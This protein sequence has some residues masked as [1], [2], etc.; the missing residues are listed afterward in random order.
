VLD[1]AVSPADLR[2][3]ALSCPSCLDV[4]SFSFP[5][6]VNL[7]VVFPLAAPVGI[8]AHGGVLFSSRNLSFYFSSL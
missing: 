6:S 2:L 1:D 5:D 3:F 7:E 8:S 4:S